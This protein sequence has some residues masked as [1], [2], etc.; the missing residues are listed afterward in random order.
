MA[1]GPGHR[2]VGAVAADPG[3]GSVSAALA[4]DHGGGA[5]VLQKADRKERG[6]GLMPVSVTQSVIIILV[7]AACTFAERLLEIFNGSIKGRL[8]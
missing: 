7:C 5:A 8:V 4:A 3:A 2:F 6:G 1:G